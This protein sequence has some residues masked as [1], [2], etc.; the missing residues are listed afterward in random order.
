MGGMRSKLNALSMNVDSSE[1]DVYV[2]VETWLFNEIRN[3]EL[4]NTSEFCV[5]RRDRH[6]VGSRRGGGV[7]LAARQ[8][9]IAHSIDLVHPS[10]EDIIEQLCVCIEGEY[11]CKLLIFVCYIPPDSHISIYLSHLN[12]IENVLSNYSEHNISVCIVGDF[13][14][15]GIKWMQYE[16]KV[17]PI[18]L[19]TEKE[20]ELIDSLFALN[21]S[22]VCFIHN[23]LQRMLDLVFI[24]DNIE[25]EIV[26]C[27]PLISNSFHHVAMSICIKNICFKNYNAFKMVDKYKY[28][29]SSSN[30]NLLNEK[31][32]NFNWQL[33]CK[34][35]LKYNFEYFVNIIFRELVTAVP[36]SLLKVNSH[37]P[38][39]NS[40]LR[41][42]KNAKNNAFKNF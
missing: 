12:N 31:F 11:D 36:R 5:F 8:S 1:Y 2:F 19:S 27:I 41:K 3:E 25:V 32:S 4:L 39:S 13:N 40:R 38:W 24:N 15:G 10:S 18:V 7:L 26:E 33:N 30:L 17:L 22:Q 6:D 34:N 42:L 9:L 16:N 29:F 21:L 14:L 37:L 23:S 20:F 35:S 28:H